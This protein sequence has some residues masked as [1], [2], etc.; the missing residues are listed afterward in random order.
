MVAKTIFYLPLENTIHIFAPPYNILYISHLS[1]SMQLL[2][3]LVIIVCFCLL[4]VLTNILFKGS[5]VSSCKEHIF[6][7]RSHLLQ[8]SCHRVDPV[9]PVSFRVTRVPDALTGISRVLGIPTPLLCC[10]R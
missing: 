8:L 6:K 5:Y 1:L 3:Q 2:Q 7:S 4:Q 9:P 10:G